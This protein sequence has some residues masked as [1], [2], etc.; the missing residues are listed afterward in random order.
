M[1]WATRARELA[2]EVGDEVVACSQQ[3][4][5]GAAAL[6]HG[7]PAGLD[8]LEDGLEQARRL[9]SKDL[10]AW[11]YMCVARGTARARLYGKTRAA[12]DTG[13]AYVGE[14]GYILWK[15]YLLAYRA[16][17]DLDQGRWDEATDS[18]QLILSERWISTKPRTVAHTVLGL[19]RARRGDPGVW[20]ALD[21]AWALAD[22]TDEPDRIAPVA[23]ARA[24]AAWLEGRNG[25]ALEATQGA[26]ELALERGVPRF[27]GELAVWRRRAGAQ[28][29]APEL[30]TDPTD[31][32]LAGEWRRAADR[33]RELGCPY[34]A[35]LADA[36]TG[37]EEA[38]RRAHED[39]RAIGATAA[40]A[41]VARRL[42]EHGVRRV[43]RG[44]RPATRSNPAGL[45]A[46]EV[47]VLALVAD[48]LRN[49]EVAE[50]LV[51]SPRTV[52][53]HVS[54]ILRKLSVRTRGEAVAA[55]T[56]IGALQDR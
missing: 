53:H 44:P 7:D 23:A 31:L 39:L 36:E 24:E 49:A 45:T 21:E 46:R 40:A 52:D 14:R 1:Y 6:L 33:W 4:T 50:R 15:L 30:A 26:Y 43:P 22:G 20:Q 10:T 18:A 19:V 56:E 11:A 35:A 48:G 34:E 8:E 2:L 29:P 12:T 27:V 3:I 5:M 13:L 55:A 42:R 16:G 41:I 25:D 28:E 17:A 9:D 37:D 38:L 54:T 32:E 47:E 51:L